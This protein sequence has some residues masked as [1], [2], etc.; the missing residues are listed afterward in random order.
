V[1]GLPDVDGARELEID[2]YYK[3]RAGMLVAEEIKASP[4]AFARKVDAE[5]NEVDR[6]GDHDGPKELAK[7]RWGN[8]SVTGTGR[9][10]APMA[11][12]V[13]CATSSCPTSPFFGEMLNPNIYF[14]LLKLRDS[15]DHPLHRSGHTP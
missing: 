7:R 12:C 14:E 10:W 11:R 6:E 9:S 2:A 5:R 4:R 15:F 13:R 8:Q 1:K 3:T